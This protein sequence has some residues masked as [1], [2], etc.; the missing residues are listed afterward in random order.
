MMEAAAIGGAPPIA[1]DDAPLR[2]RKIRHA[3]AS[4][5]EVGERTSWRIARLH[6]PQDRLV[7][8]DASISAGSAAGHRPRHGV[9][10][11]L[12][13]ETLAHPPAARG[14]ES[15]TP[16]CAGRGMQDDGARHDRAR[17]AAPPTSSAPATCTNPTRRSAFSSVRVADTDIDEVRS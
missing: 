11:N 14:F 16:G 4:T 10:P 1:V 6:R 13:V 3:E 2:H 17:Q 15:R 12:L 9:A 5:T 8:V 7:T